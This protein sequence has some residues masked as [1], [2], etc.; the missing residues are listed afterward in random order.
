MN[1]WELFQP[2]LDAW[3]SSSNDMT[4]Y[5]KDSDSVE[6]SN[7]LLEQDSTEWVS[8]AAWVCRVHAK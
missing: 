3:E 8:H 6:S 7:K 1:N 4:T 2:V 5:E